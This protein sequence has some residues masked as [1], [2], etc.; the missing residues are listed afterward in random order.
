[1]L[2][3]TGKGRTGPGVLKKSAPEWLGE[4]PI[5]NVVLKF[6]PAKPKDGGEGALYVYLCRQ[7]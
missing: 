3:I 5:A 7:R 2:V 6:Y 1:M 4:A